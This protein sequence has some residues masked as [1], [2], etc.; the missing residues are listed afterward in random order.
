MIDQADVDFVRIGARAVVKLDE[1]P[2]ATLVGKVAAVAQIDLQVAPRELADRG[3]LPSR[4]D[5]AGNVHPLETAY[6]ARI[7]LED[8][9]QPLRSRAAGRAKIDAGSQSLGARLW[10]SLEGTFQFHW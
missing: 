8:R 6:Q 10:R 3:D 9:P 7:T 1:L 2:D 4:V 5:A